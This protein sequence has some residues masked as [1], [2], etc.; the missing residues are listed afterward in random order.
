MKRAQAS[1]RHQLLTRYARKHTQREN[2]PNNCAARAPRRSLRA[3][4]RGLPYQHGA[5]DA[6]YA[7]ASARHDQQTDSVLPSVILRLSL[8]HLYTDCTQTR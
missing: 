5:S 8:D 2:M 1:A 3:N 7:S 4:G 6:H